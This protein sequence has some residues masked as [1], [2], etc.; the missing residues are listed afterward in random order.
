[1]LSI[2][3]AHV[4][5]THVQGVG[6]EL[7]VGRRDPQVIE[8]LPFAKAV[9]DIYFGAHPVTDDMKSELVSRLRR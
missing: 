7:R 5:F 6:V 8:G 1:M 9:W 4:R 2:G 3:P